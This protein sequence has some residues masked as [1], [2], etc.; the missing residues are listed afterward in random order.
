METL[1]LGSAADNQILHVA[2]AEGKRNF[3]A[4]RNSIIIENKQF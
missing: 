4:K 2:A 3:S 1:T